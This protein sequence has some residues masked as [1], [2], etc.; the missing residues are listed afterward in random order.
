MTDPVRGEIRRA[1]QDAAAKLAALVDDLTTW[2]GPE[3]AP[4]QERIHAG[5]RSL[6]A[7]DE[8]LSLL[9]EQR[10]ALA[11]AL[12]ASTGRVVVRRRDGD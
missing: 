9:T 10:T 7:L 12:G 2:D 3:D 5:Y 4:E 8:V 11:S 6:P 1:I